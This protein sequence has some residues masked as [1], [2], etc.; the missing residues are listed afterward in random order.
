MILHQCLKGLPHPVIVLRFLL[1]EPLSRFKL[2]VPHGAQG[3]PQLRQTSARF[4]AGQHDFATYLSG[5]VDFCETVLAVGIRYITTAIPFLFHHSRGAIG[6]LQ[7]SL[8]IR[9]RR[10]SRR[11]QST[12]RLGDADQIRHFQNTLLDSL[13]SISP[14]GRNAQ[15][16]DIHALRN[17]H[18]GLSQSHRFQQHHVVHLSQQPQRVVGAL[19]GQSAQ[20]P[21]RRGSGSDVNAI[22]R[23]R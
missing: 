3:L 14:S 17:F 18:F 21:L 13:Q 19:S 7:G 22:V 16:H 12:I 15:D 20:R 11:F 9:R 2:M 10:S 4:G 8:I 23:G 5:R 1:V 6:K